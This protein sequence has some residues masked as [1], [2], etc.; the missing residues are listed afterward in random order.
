M[1]AAGNFDTVPSLNVG[2]S[3][4]F[5]GTAFPYGLPSATNVSIVSAVNQVDEVDDVVISGDGSS[6]TYDSSADTFHHLST[7]AVWTLVP[8][9]T[10]VVVVGQLQGATDVNVGGTL[11]DVEFVEGT[12]VDLYDGCDDLSDFTFTTVADAGLAARALQ[13][14][15]ILDGGAGN[16]DT[17]PN[18]TV[19]CSGA[20]CGTAFPFALPNATDVTI[21]SAV[22]QAAETGDLFGSGDTARTFDSSTGSFHTLTT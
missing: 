1:A 6:R 11:Y 21:F 3:G 10:P 7:Y 22:N 2:C 19:G 15:V 16:F 20:F 9:A 4:S 18:L 14:Q 13:D 12:C 5:C 17:V 8:P